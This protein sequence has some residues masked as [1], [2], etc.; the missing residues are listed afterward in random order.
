MR[1]EQ[2]TRKALKGY[3]EARGKEVSD[4]TVRVELAALRKAF[5][6]WVEDADEDKGEVRTAPRFPKVAAGDRREGVI[7]ADEIERVIFHL[8]E[9]LKDVA[10][11]AYIVGW[12]KLEILGLRWQQV[13]ADLCVVTLKAAQ[14]KNKKPRTLPYATHP[15]L[16][17]LMRRRQNARKDLCP[18]VFHR[19]GKPIADFHDT[20]RAACISAGIP[21]ALFHDTRRS[22]LTNLTRNGV[23][24]I[25]AMKISGHRNRDVFDRYQIMDDADVADA[26]GKVSAGNNP[27]HNH[28]SEGISEKSQ[29]EEG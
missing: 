26:L 20:W 9:H 17:A 22:A 11:F 7:K 14:S 19:D 10:R 24:A 5:T 15:E 13:D 25:T 6:L 29:V 8:P 18:W 12:R 4:G 3:C 27:G 28:D 2:I 21:K 16:L 1:V 23:P